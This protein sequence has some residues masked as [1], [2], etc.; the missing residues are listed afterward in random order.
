MEQ[1]FHLNS[2][3]KVKIHYCGVYMTCVF[4]LP[5]LIRVPILAEL[6]QHWQNLLKCKKY[7]I[8]HAL[9]GS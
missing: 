8:L 3:I 9:R 5:Y 2:L 4:G 7:K 6:F 1:P